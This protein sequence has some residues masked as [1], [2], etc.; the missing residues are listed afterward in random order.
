MTLNAL[1]A[2]SNSRANVDWNTCGQA[3][4]ATVLDFHGA[5]PF[6]LPRSSNGH[7]NSGQVIDALKHDGQ[8]PDV[9]FGWGTTP[10]RIE[11][12]LQRYGLSAVEVAPNP[13]GNARCREAAAKSRSQLFLDLEAYLATDR[14]APVL[15][16]LGAMGGS[17]Y[18]AHWPVAYKVENGKVFL[19]NCPWNPSPTVNQFISAWHAWFLPLGMNWATVYT[20]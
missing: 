9:V 4:I 20:G 19:G 18:T 12:A 2:Y 7:W 15:V 16:D 6:G 11:G 1:Y 13:L 10:W 5:D 8:G 14:P 3:A 17:Y